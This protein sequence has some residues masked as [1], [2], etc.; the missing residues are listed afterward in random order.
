MKTCLTSTALLGKLLLW[1][2]LFCNGCADRTPPV[3]P[4]PEPEPVAS[5]EDSI[6]I[7]DYVTA[8]DN[9][10]K[11]N[12]FDHALDTIEMAAELARDYPNPYLQT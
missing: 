11:H 10:K 2:M 8:F 3:K 7:V 5:K 1:F 12:R 9:A 6:K 4:T